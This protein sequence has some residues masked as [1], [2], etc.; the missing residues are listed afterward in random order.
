MEEMLEWMTNYVNNIDYKRADSY[1]V[2]IGTPEGGCSLPKGR[3][4]TIKK[5]PFQAICEIYNCKDTDI[6][7]IPYFD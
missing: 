2:Q 6:K 1:G 5:I 7:V 4:R 3:W